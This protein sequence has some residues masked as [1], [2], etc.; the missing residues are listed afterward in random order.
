MIRRPKSVS[1]A[2]KVAFLIFLL[3][4]VPGALFAQGSIFGEV[5]NSDFS[6]P[7]NG[8]ISFFGYLDDTDEEIR[9][10]SCTGAGYDNGNWYDDFQNYQ[11]ESAGNPYDYHFFNSANGESYLLSGLIPGNSSQQE[12][13]QLEILTRPA[14]PALLSATSV[15][16]TA[17]KITWE[18]TSGL[19]YHIYRRIAPSNSSL[20]RIDDPSGSLS[21]P[22]VSGGEYIDDVTG[23]VSVGQTV[24]YMI[25]AEDASGNLS[26]H[27]DIISVT[28]HRTVW[29]IATDGSDETGDGSTS[30]PFATIQHGIDTSQDGDTLLLAEGIYSG[31][32]NQNITIP[33]ISVAIIGGSGHQNTI[34]DLN[35]ANGFIVY[36]SAGNSVSL[37]FDNLTIK[38][39]VNVFLL[40]TDDFV[41]NEVSLNINE[42][43][44]I[45]NDTGL[46]YIDFG[47]FPFS[48]NVSNSTFQSNGIGIFLMYGYVTIKSSVFIENDIAISTSKN[49]ASYCGSLVDSSTFDGNNTCILGSTIISNSDLLNCDKALYGSSWDNKS[50][51]LDEHWVDNCRFENVGNIVFHVGGYTYVRNSEVV[52]N[53]GDIAYAHYGSDMYSSDIIFDSCFIYNNGGG[54]YSGQIIKLK[55]SQ[56]IDNGGGL[57]LNAMS[58]AAKLEVVNSVISSNNSDAITISNGYN[59]FINISNASIM[60]NQG[61]GIYVIESG[62]MNVI[63]TIIANNSEHGII[64]GYPSLE[65]ACSDVYNNTIADYS[66]IPDQTGL[67]GNISLDPLFCD[68]A[69]GNF[70]LF[71]TS[72]CVP[73]NNSCGVL[74]GALGVGCYIPACD[75]VEIDTLHSNLNVVDHTPLISWNFIDPGSS[76]LISTEIAVGSDNDWAFAEMWNPAPFV[77]PD[78]FVTYNGSPL[79][80][81][82]TYYLRLRVNNGLIWS[83]WYET[84]FRMNSVPWTPFELTPQL[85][86]LVT[87]DQPWLLI[88]VSYDPDGDNVTYDYLWVNDPSFGPSDTFGVIGSADIT[89]QITQPLN[90]NWR[91]LWAARA[92]DGFE[93]SDWSASESFWVNSIN[94]PP[95]PF[96]TQSPPDE[97]GTPVYDL[98]PTFTWT[99]P[100]DPDPFDSMHYNLIVATDPGFNFSM[101]IGDI[102]SNSHT[103]TDSLSFGTQYWWKVQAVDDYGLITDC[104]NI[105]DFK[106]WKLGDVNANWAVDILD[107]VYLVNFK[108]KGGPAP[109]PL[110]SGDIDG[111]CVINILDIVYLV[112]YKFKTG[113]DPLPGCE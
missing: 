17:I 106:T 6:V 31:I 58:A 15:S 75:T 22:G 72:P 69:N 28:H 85:D 5:T 80:D 10:E 78:T 46:A 70:S 74:M 99:V 66:G 67:N 90:D 97:M 109:T 96:Q 79:T 2:I 56:F 107:I 76:S 12:N 94:E 71:S 50:E 20:Y 57:I 38:N 55:N 86:T 19:T 34:I 112:N 98:L 49:Y 16:E 33:S 105:R 104:D 60:G 26:P 36:D 88:N 84:S 111:N 32:G 8:D 83:E 1:N 24:D 27:S 100:T 53:P 37:L 9:V 11:T 61:N 47:G 51:P 59:D 48:S 52:N 45:G 54:V 93:Y 92:S 101:T 13:I 91:Y 95:G 82:T 18:E 62:G 81:G 42:C 89:T 29:Y 14:K 40:N 30:N 35:S 73:E 39:G 102:P 103:L 113:P 21:N 68:T 43:E 44:I 4:A 110:Y 87:S 63:N 65:I 7:A 23:I 77:S 25:I 3:F 41:W 64:I 108:F